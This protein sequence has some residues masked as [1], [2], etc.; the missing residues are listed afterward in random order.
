MLSCGVTKGRGLICLLVIGL[1]IFCTGAYAQFL[2]GY[3]ITDYE[4][5]EW[6]F[7]TGQIDADEFER[8]NEFFTDSLYSS[9]QPIDPM[10]NAEDNQTEWKTYRKSLQFD[11]RIYHKCTESKP[12]RQVIGVRTISR[13]G[14]Y[15]DI[16][17]E[18][19]RDRRLYFRDRRLGWSNHDTYVELGGLDP[20]WCGGLIL[21]RHPVF[22]GEK[23]KEKSFLYPLKARFNGAS[24]TKEIN[25]IDISALSSY[26]KDEQ[27]SATVNGVRI[28]YKYGKHAVNVSVIRGCLKDM[29]EKIDKVVVLKYLKS[30]GI[31]MG[32]SSSKS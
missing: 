22:L 28:G 11:Y 17:M 29:T 20:L 12:Y 27:F 6:L 10:K 24:I 21:G 3:I 25:N 8:W 32:E 31:A 30:P 5:L 1:S 13:R 26:D 7:E 14:F 18:Q 15:C 16:N 9:R 19:T 2:N 4:T 23:D